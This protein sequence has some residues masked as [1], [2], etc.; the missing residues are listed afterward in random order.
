MSGKNYEVPYS[1]ALS[2]SHS[3]TFGPNIVLRILS[4]LSSLN[5]KVSVSKPC[6][7]KIIFRKSLNFEIN[8]NEKNELFE[9][10]VKSIVIVL[11]VKVRESHNVCGLWKNFDVIFAVWSCAGK[12][13]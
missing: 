3:Q 6:N 4:L 1:Q 11:D 2:T 12:C 8:F 5:V 13:G 10:W 9:E 7:F